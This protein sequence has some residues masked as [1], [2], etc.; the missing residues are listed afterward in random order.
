MRDITERQKAALSGQSVILDYA[1]DECPALEVQYY[2]PEV[3]CLLSVDDA[4]GDL[5]SKIG[6]IDSEATDTTF[7]INSSAFTYLH[8][9]KAAVNA[10]PYYRAICHAL[11]N[12][13]PDNALLLIADQQCKKPDSYTC[14]IDHLVIAQAHF[15]I[16]ARNLA[17]SEAHGDAACDWDERGHVNRLLQVQFKLADSD[18]ATTIKVYNVKGPT[19][20][21]EVLQIPLIAATGVLQQSIMETMFG[22]PIKS[23]PGHRLVVVIMNTTNWF[24]TYT[25]TS[26]V[27]DII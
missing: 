20:D 10:V 17:Q 3:S 4:T 1:A 13:D 15:S 27:G 6:D 23:K 25:L 19:V 14:L 9:M 7:V 22:D 12:I 8:E 11:P 26:I 24:D 21:A 5:S 2:G 16:S 18:W